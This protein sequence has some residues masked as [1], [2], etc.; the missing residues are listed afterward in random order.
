MKA[1][2]IIPEEEKVENLFE[3]FAN[4]YNTQVKHQD[5]TNAR[6]IFIRG[7]INITEFDQEGKTEIRVSGATKD[8]LEYLQSI[9]GKPI[10][11]EKEPLNMNDFIE[12]INSFPNIQEKSHQEIIEQLDLDQQT[13]N[14]YHRM[15]KMMKRRPNV[16]P[17]ILTALKLLK[18]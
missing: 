13:F 8:D 15:L 12:R 3:Q 5:Q 6:F 9:L 10:S 18:R 17:E 2:F 16:K 11:V 14:K 1:S 4:N 7:R